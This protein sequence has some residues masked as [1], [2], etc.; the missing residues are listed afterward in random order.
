MW[1]SGESGGLLKAESFLS[2][3]FVDELFD[4]VRDNVRGEGGG[5][6]CDV[7]SANVGARCL[8]GA[9]ESGESMLLML[10]PRLIGTLACCVPGTGFRLTDGTVGTEWCLA[11]ASGLHWLISISQADLFQAAME[12]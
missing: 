11:G 7:V 4:A 12:S 9:G 2:A 3:P 10:F 1:S 5:D 6:H 8:K